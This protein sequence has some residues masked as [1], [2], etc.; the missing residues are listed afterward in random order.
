[1]SG[2]GRCSALQLGTGWRSTADSLRPVHDVDDLLALIDDPDDDSTRAYEVVAELVASG[3]QSLVPRLRDELERFLDSKHFYG[4]DVIADVI[5]GL[6]GA[7]ALPLLLAASARDLGDDQDSL[8]STIVEAMWMDK[9]R[10]GE[11]LADLRNSADHRMAAIAVRT[12][13][14]LEWLRQ[15]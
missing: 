7:E 3:D 9:D 15:R 2:V 5:A 4:R 10:A 6:E 13:K 1:L 12:G 11:I 14:T 8:Q